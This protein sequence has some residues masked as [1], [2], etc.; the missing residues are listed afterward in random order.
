M[1]LQEGYFK[2]DCLFFLRFVH[3]IWNGDRKMRVLMKKVFFLL[4]LTRLQAS[5]TVIRTNF[6]N[7]FTMNLLE[8]MPLS[9]RI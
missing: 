3:F 4:G 8:S 2:K 6:R 1:S 7:M 9:L 5:V